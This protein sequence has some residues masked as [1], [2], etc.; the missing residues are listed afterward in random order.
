MFTKQQLIATQRFANSVEKKKG[1]VRLEINSVEFDSSIGETVYQFG[2]FVD[3]STEQLWEDP[4]N[5]DPYRERREMCANS[6]VIETNGN[7]SVH[8][9]FCMEF[10]SI[11]EM[12][13]EILE[14]PDP[15]MV[16]DFKELVDSARMQLLG[17][18]HD[19]LADA[20]TQNIDR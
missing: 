9:N 1:T 18:S 13:A 5:V 2:Q 6:F 15:G 10:H 8:G 4:Q 20:T 17:T 12:L 11:D 19:G 7:V 3:D 14:E 16:A